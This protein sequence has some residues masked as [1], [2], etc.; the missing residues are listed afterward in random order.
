MK[1]CP[2]NVLLEA[3]SVFKAESQIIDGLWKK[4]LRGLLDQ[5]RPFFRK[6]LLYFEQAEV[7]Q[8]SWKVIVDSFL[9]E[10]LGDFLVFL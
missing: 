6:V 3:E 5:L 10:I 4:H 9:V 8:R 2:V 1:P 7:V